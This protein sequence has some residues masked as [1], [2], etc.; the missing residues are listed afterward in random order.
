MMTGIGIDG[1]C[2]STGDASFKEFRTRIQAR[3]Q[4]SSTKAPPQSHA[5]NRYVHSG[6]VVVEDPGVPATGGG[7]GI[8]DDTVEASGPKG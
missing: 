8:A 4:T 3:T 6:F 7:T 5:A 1:N 2:T